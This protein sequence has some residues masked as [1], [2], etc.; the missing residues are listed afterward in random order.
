MRLLLRYVARMIASQSHSQLRPVMKNKLLQIDGGAI[1]C[2]W[3]ES[4]A[5]QFINDLLSCFIKQ[6]FCEKH[7]TIYLPTAPLKIKLDFV[8]TY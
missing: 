3:N 1:P 2:V 8:F 6:V 7:N 5:G 4:I